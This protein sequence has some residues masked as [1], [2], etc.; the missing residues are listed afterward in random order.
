VISF[1]GPAHNE[2]RLIEGTLC[3]IRD[4]AE[5]LGEPYEVI[6]AADACTDRTAEIAGEHGCRVLTVNHRQIAGTRNSGARAAQGE[7]LFFVDADTLVTPESVR[8]SVDALRNGAVAGGCLCTFDGV[9]PLWARVIQPVYGVVCRTIGLVGGCSLFCTRAAF[10]TIGGFSEQQFAAEE[11]V[12]IQT[13]KRHGRFVIPT[14]TVVT[15]GRKLRSYSGWRVMGVILRVATHG[16]KGFQSR[17]GLDM[18]YADDR[19]RL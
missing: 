17:E 11:M 19:S 4:A 13:M 16:P 14:P 15:S 5:A 9:L 1:I 10:E 12:F 6:V 2:E 18:W 8:A 7:I 3:S